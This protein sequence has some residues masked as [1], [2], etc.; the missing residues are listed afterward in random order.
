VED[1]PIIEPKPTACVPLSGGTDTQPPSTQVSCCY[2]PELKKWYPYDTINGWDLTA[3]CQG[4]VIEST[5]SAP[6][7]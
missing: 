4:G 2:H 7:A 5:P 3:E 1:N 6:E